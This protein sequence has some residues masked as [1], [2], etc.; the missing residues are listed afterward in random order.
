[1]FRQ[2]L[3]DEVLGLWALDAH[4]HLMLPE[5]HAKE[6]TDCF[7]L[8]HHYLNNDLVSAGMPAEEMQALR[9]ASIPLEQRW[10]SFA[11]WWEFARTTGYGQA[12]ERCVRD[13][14]GLEGLNERTYRPLSELVAQQAGRVEWYE[15]IFKKKGRFIGCLADIYKL[16]DA[17]TDRRYFLPIMRLD[18]WIMARTRKEVL[19]RAEHAV[20][21]ASETAGGATRGSTGAN[22]SANGSP[23]GIREPG[24]LAGYLRGI[25]AVL[26]RFVDAGVVG[27]KCGLA[28]RR[29][30]AF[31]VV[32]RGTAERL[33]ERALRDDLSPT[34]AKPLQDFLF[35]EVCDRAAAHGLPYQVHTGLQAGNTSPNG[36]DIMR[37]N[38]ALLTPALRAHPRTRFDLFHGGYPYGGEL[39]T[40]AKNLPNVFINACWLAIISPTVLRRQLHEWLDTVP[41]NKIQAFGGDYRM[42]ELSY[43]HGLMAR[44]E[45][46]HVL[47]ERVEAGYLAEAD[48]PVLARR[49]L[50]DN[51]IALFTL[52]AEHVQAATAPL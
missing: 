26:E 50:A 41:H 10:R 18:T 39:A 42:P 31:D 48:A 17:G 23:A 46:A 37:T 38:P 6:A 51:G 43:A 19:E 29:S 22:G 27:L 40:L 28:Y 5:E 52:S 21:L 44:E 34:E 25:D 12:V 35:H 1:M 30:L 7:Y 20:R 36:P 45:L 14:F 47:A 8:T 15:H 33:F 32:E 2:E 49:L 11:P 9:D 16:P 3:R 13:L 24:D 4:E